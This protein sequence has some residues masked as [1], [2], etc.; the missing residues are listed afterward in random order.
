MNLFLT[1]VFFLAFGTSI[2]FLS[3]LFIM[4]ASK[5]KPENFRPITNKDIL[6]YNIVMFISI[7]LWSV[8]FYFRNTIS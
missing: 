5:I 3:R 7:L 4:I 2:W 8:L 1:F 6:G